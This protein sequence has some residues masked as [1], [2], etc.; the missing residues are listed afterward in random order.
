MFFNQ[1]HAVRL[2]IANYLNDQ[3]EHRWPFC[4]GMKRY[5][6]L[7]D[8]A[9]VSLLYH[10]QSWPIR[11]VD[12]YY[13][14]RYCLFL[15]ELPTRFGPLGT[16]FLLELLVAQHITDTSVENLF[17]FVGSK[18]LFEVRPND[19]TSVIIR[20]LTRHCRDIHDVRFYL[21]DLKKSN[22]QHCTRGCLRM[23]VYVYVYKN[24]KASEKVKYFR[25]WKRII[26]WKRL[27]PVGD[28]RRD[29]SRCLL[30]S[31]SILDGNSRPLSI[32]VQTWAF[33]WTDGSHAWRICG[34][35][36]T[37]CPT[38]IGERRSGSCAVAL[39]GCEWSKQTMVSHWAKHLTLVLVQSHLIRWK[40]TSD[41]Q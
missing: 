40:T 14:A 9:I 34:H 21:E 5:P 35:Y 23:Y 2:A 27:K 33:R 39:G 11:S 28:E 8:E 41:D 30:L 1:A 22:A 26:L 37:V 31:V 19:V 36:Q 12:I 4:K 16:G 3:A 17:H 15:G 13:E 32:L 24:I 6:W 20:F 38:R 7:I 10:R 29:F 18:F 25:S